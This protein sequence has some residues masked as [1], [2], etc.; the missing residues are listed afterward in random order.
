[1]LS[2]K[3]QDAHRLK[4]AKRAERI[5]IRGVFRRLEAHLHMALR[6][7]IIDFVGAGILQ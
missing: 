6:R 1:M 3:T 4:Q 5:G 2:F 7:E